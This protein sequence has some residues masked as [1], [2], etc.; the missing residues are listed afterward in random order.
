MKNKLKIICCGQVSDSNAPPQLQGSWGVKAIIYSRYKV[1][2]EIRIKE[3]FN[4]F[5]RVTGM[6]SIIVIPISVTGNIQAITP[7]KGCNKGEELKTALNV[8]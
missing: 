7:A 6:K 4:P 3:A 2:I 8:S 1:K 5:T